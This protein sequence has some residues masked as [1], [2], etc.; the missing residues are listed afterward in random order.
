MMKH[1]QSAVIL[2]FCLMAFSVQAAENSSHSLNIVSFNI[3]YNNP[4]DGEHAWPNRKSHV[5]SLL[6]FHDADIIGMQ[7]VLAKQISD[8]EKL[9]PN[10]AWVGVGRN[11]GVSAGEFSPIFYKVDRFRLEESGTFWLSEDPQEIG[12]KSWDAALPRIATWAVFYDRLNDSQFLHLNTHFDHRGEVA[13]VESAKLIIAQLPTLA[14]ALPWVVTGDFNKGPGS[15]VH[16]TMT[17]QLLDSLEVSINPPHGPT[18]TFGGFTVDLDEVSDRIDYVFVKPG[19]VVHRYAA[20]SDQLNGRY[21]SDHLPVLAE[22]S[23]P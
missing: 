8:L 6:H 19:I 9:L 11:D 20:L 10:Y 16:Q 22:I 4:N 14:P 12:T 13:R 5:G 1:I 15:E 18:G 7:E 2:A 3:R 23:L 21:P 17:S